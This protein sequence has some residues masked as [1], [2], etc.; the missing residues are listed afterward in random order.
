MALTTYKEARPWA[1]AIKEEILERK[2]PPWSAAS[3]YGHFA[4]DMSL[5]AREIS[6]IL[7]WADG[8]APSGVLLVDEDK[9]P[10]FVPSLTSW[11]QGA[12]DAMITVAEKQKIAADSPFRV[13]RFEVATGLKQARWL[14]ALQFNPADRR[15]DSLRR[16]L[17]CAQRAMARHVDA[18]EPGERACP[19]DRACSCRPA[20]S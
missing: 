14:R 13:E 10:V 11:E 19:R 6:L 4:N 16:H 20:R 5:T 2:M 7:S 12:P 18:V 17:R 8:G 1:V 15:V 3:G 9:Q